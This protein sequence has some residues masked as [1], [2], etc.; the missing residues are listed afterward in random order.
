MLSAWQAHGLKKAAFKEKAG[1][2]DGE[3]ETTTAGA[4]SLPKGWSVKLK[5]RAHGA[6]KGKRDRYYVCPAGRE[7]RSLQEVARA[8]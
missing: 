3:E 6:S 1:V 4:V 8:F 5:V 2:G 7:Y